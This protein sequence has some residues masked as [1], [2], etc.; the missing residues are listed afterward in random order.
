MISKLYEQRLRKNLGQLAVL[1]LITVV[2]WMAV[3][4]YRS[5]HKSQL[6]PDVKKQILPLTPSIDLDTMESIKQRQVVSE[7]DWSSL[8]PSGVVTLLLPPSPIA[9]ESA[10]PTA[11]PS[12]TASPSGELNL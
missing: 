5:L 2:I 9:T 3:A 7:A 11:S 1:T 6:T 12:A 8:Q 10:A 4:V